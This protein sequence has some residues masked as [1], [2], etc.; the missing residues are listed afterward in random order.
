MFFGTIINAT[1]VRVVDGD[2]VRLQAD[3]REQSVRLLALDTEES[4]RGSVT[5]P[6]TPWGRKAKEEPSASCLRATLSPSSSLGRNPWRNAW[7][8]I[9]TTSGGC[10]V[11]CTR[12]AWTFRS[13]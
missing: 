1:V 6:V 13:T 7:R 11:S 3:G 8:N 4:N 10:S 9:A 2:T 5:K 12:T